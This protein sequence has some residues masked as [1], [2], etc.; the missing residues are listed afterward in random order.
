MNLKGTKTEANLW[1]AF[2]GESQARN[3]YTYF[4]SAAK[5]E[6]F[7]Q[8]AAIF[9]ET[10]NNEK[11]HAKMWFKLAT[12]GIGSTAENLK[13]AVDFVN[14]A[15]ADPASGLTQQNYFQN[16]KL[17]EWKL[18]D[19]VVGFALSSGGLGGSGGSGSSSGGGSGSG[20]SGG[21]SGSGSNSGATT[22]TTPSTPAAGGSSFSDV[23][24]GAYYKSAVDWAV[25]KKITSGKTATLFA[26]DDSCTR[27]QAVTFLWRAA[28]SPEPASAQNSFTDVSQNAYYYKA[29]LWAVEKGITSG[30]SASTFSPE[31]TISRAEMATFLWRYAE[32]P[33]AKSAAGFS[34]VDAAAYYHDAVAWAASNGITS[35][36]SSSTFDPDGNCTR[37]QIVT[38]LYRYMK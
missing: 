9:E 27:A 38:F 21:G 18:A 11:E 22:P 19:N 29:V 37:G 25:E 23:P 16:N 28:G 20:S 26:P 8:I 5:K 15:I 36:T 6:G 33:A 3:K 7:N 10:A 1:A 35:G 14:A 24:A 2:A 12:G 31:K 4:S 13:A 34:D 30:T 32:T 17:L